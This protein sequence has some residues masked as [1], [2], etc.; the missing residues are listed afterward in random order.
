M[1]MYRFL[2]LLLDETESNLINSKL[3]RCNALLYIEVI[4]LPVILFS[5]LDFPPRF[6]ILISYLDFPTL[7][8]F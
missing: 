3:P 1:S 5:Y 8:T 6:S 2:Y 7:L 4:S